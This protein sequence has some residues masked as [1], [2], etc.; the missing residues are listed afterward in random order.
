M[1]VSFITRLLTLVL[2]YAYPAYDCYKTLELSTPQMEQLRFWCQYWESGRR[3]QRRQGKGFCVYL[4]LVRRFRSGNPLMSMGCGGN[5]EE[6]DGGVHSLAA[7][8]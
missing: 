4:P 5:G 2:C 3:R 8:T 7:V 6:G 1:A